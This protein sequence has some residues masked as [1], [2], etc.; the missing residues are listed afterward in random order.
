[1]PICRRFVDTG[2]KVMDR[3]H[4]GFYS[5]QVGIEIQGRIRSDQPR[6]FELEIILKGDALIDRYRYTTVQRGYLPDA[7]CTISFA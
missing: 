4:E 7:N 6:Y 2:Q 5:V 3:K 1:M